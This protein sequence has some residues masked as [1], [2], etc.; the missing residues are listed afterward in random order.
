MTVGSD[1]ASVI[2]YIYTDVSQKLSIFPCPG[3]EGRRLL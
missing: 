1:V 2:R 3:E